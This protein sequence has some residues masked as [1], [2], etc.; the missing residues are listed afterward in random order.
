MSGLSYK[1]MTTWRLQAKK[2]IKKVS[3]DTNYKP[4]VI[5]PVD[6]FNFETPPRYQSDREV[7][8]YDLHHVETSDL[9]VVNLSQL[10][11]SI[12]TIIELYRA[13]QLGIPVIAFGYMT[14]YDHLHSWIK[15]CITRVEKNLENVANYI[16]EFYMS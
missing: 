2:L 6:Y 16:Y 4:E 13:Y 10:N 15:C 3:F 9:I 14:E 1:D 7:M 12:G 11:S 8:N 5:N